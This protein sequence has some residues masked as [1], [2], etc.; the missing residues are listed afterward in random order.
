MSHTAFGICLSQSESQEAAICKISGRYVEYI[1][2]LPFDDDVITHII[3]LVDKDTIIAIGLADLTTKL[4]QNLQESGFNVISVNSKQPIDT[5]KDQSKSQFLN[6]ES[7][8]WYLIRGALDPESDHPIA[9]PP[10]D[11]LSQCLTSIIGSKENGKIIATTKNDDVRHAGLALA[12][13]LYA[14]DRRK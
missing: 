1:R 8:L 12:L 13:A 10:D 2:Y 4:I 14:S 9:I 11:K 6:I 7:F 5:I 3:R